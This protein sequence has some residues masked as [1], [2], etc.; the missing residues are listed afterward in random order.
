MIVKLTYR[1]SDY[2]TSEIIMDTIPEEVHERA[3]G[4][5]E[6]DGFKL[7]VAKVDVTRIVTRKSLKIISPL[8]LLQLPHPTVLKSL[9]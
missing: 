6:V 2:W 8:I 5:D 1:P 9:P 3:L 7:D 4:R